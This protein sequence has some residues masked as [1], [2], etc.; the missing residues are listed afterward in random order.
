M[1]ILKTQIVFFLISIVW[2]GINHIHA[3]S[4]YP[5]QSTPKMKVNLKVPLKAYAFDL[6]NIKLL[7]SPFK[8]NQKRDAEWLSSLDNNLLLLSFRITA[9]MPPQ[10]SNNDGSKT[11]GG[12]EALH[13]E[14]RGHTMGHVLSALALM[15]A[16][17]GDHSFKKKGAELVTELAKVQKA[18]DRGG[19]LSAFPEELV[20]RA[21]EEKPVW[22]PWYTLHKIV[23]GLIDQYLY[24]DNEESLQVAM[25]M[26]DWAFTKLSKLDQSGLDK[27]LRTE[28][29]GMGEPFYNLYA[30]TGEMK[31]KNLAEMFYRKEVLDPLS[32]GKDQLK[33][34]HANTFIPIVTV[35]A[36]GY[37]LTACEKQKNTAVF[38]WQ[39]VIDHHT[40]AIGGNSNREHFFAPDNLSQ[41]LSRHSM[42]SCNTYNM[43]KLTNHL[44]TWTG[45]IKYADYYEQALYNH[46]L[47]TQC[48]ETGMT[49]YYMSHEPGTF[50][51]YST[52]NHSFW[53]CTGTGFENH[54][55][56]GEAIYFH[57]NDGVYVN[58]F[59]PSVLDWKEKGLKVRQET[60]YP[61]SD[62]TKL[63]I[64][65][66][67]SNAFTIRVR[68][69]SWAKS[70]ALVTI[71]GKKQSI[72][73]KPGSYI[74][75]S[76]KW[77]TGDVIEI[78]YPMQLHLVFANDNS[79][80]A[81]IA[82][83]P[84]VL[85]GAMGTE[86]MDSPY[87]EE[88]WHGVNFKV[89]QGLVTSIQTKGENVAKWIKPVGDEP[90]TFEV[91]NQPGGNIKLVPYYRMHHQRYVVYWT[92]NK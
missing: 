13:V 34:Y 5:G 10:I 32:E 41:N 1:K 43:L 64:E 6:K 31:Y 82:Y 27:M 86:N 66:T 65:T 4:L 25:K 8:E 81:A 91:T 73:N 19:Y 92:L 36:R 2:V 76:R 54:A 17:T 70:G 89:P 42:E 60:T 75:L 84:I 80:L 16:S 74:E 61:E 33:G 59:I 11:L 26:G 9:G 12:W 38:F 37:E 69:P 72:K 29:G 48:P 68:Y 62:K 45:D 79:N 18:M 46:I 30:L 35:E 22:A 78:Q 7:D 87:A 90:L 57:D 28:Y 85:A 58:L 50:K 40:F 20:D 55:K 51:V 63:I 83:G 15:D 44:F 24:S 71:N 21:I 47:G 3:Q 14:L 23:A 53:C 39:T 56:Y 49:C 88:Q 67:P 77:Q 52:K